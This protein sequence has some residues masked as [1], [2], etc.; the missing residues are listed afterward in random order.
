MEYLIILF[1][2][3]YQVYR[4]DILENKHSQKPYIISALI[5]TLLAA[6]RYRVGG[7]TIGYMN[8]YSTLPELNELV[9]S[10]LFGYIY[11]PIWILLCS[12][13]KLFSQDFILLQ[14]FHSIFV[15]FVC[16]S[17]IKKYS[18][19]PFS[20][21]LIYFLFVYWNFS[22]EVL[23]ASL[24]ISI[25]L[26][27]Y[28]YFEKKKWIK[29]YML[30][31]LCF[32]IHYSSIFLFFLPLFRNVK[33]N[34]K[35]LFLTIPLIPILFLTAS[36]IMP[37]FNLLLFNEAIKSKGLTYFDG[38]FGID[39][40][41]FM[42]FIFN[43]I[44]DI[45]LP[46]ICL[47][48]YRKYRPNEQTIASLVVVYIFTGLINMAIPI[49]YRLSE[50]VSI[51]YVIIVSDV[52]ILIVRKRFNK[53]VHFPVFIILLFAISFFQISD[54]FRNFSEYPAKVC[55]KYYPYYSIFS[56]KEDRTREYVISPN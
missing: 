20:T 40:F 51:F 50:F 15:N 45:F 17:F 10:N 36:S 21:A 46:M 41:S 55:I 28:P 24:A 25:F 19:H 16:F 11:E 8:L 52:L 13:F 7:D 54:L 5:C 47:L 18:P 39:N 2:F 30:A 9:H 38:G 26:L 3:I 14:I 42:R 34:I 27:G 31:L 35:A 6:F 23:R 48:V 56:K 33:L 32:F 22:F 37:Y 4:Y 44:R 43:Y 1:L 29:F 49:F 53:L 12:F